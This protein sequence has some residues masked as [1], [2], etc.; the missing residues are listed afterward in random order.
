MTARPFRAALYIPGS[1]PRALDKARGLA[2]DA[3]LFD[4]EDAVS[5]DEKAAARKTLAEELEAGGYGERMR[6]VRMN[7]LGTDWGK[8]DATAIADMA[9]DAVLVPKVAGPD[10]VD[11]VRAL[12]PDLPV[13]AMIES[14]AG[15]L[16]AAAIAA[17]PAMQGFVIGTND[18]A[19]DLGSRGRPALTTALQMTLL[20]A[21][22]AGIS[23]SGR[24]RSVR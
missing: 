17:H 15:V 2:V 14:P 16:N 8:D 18:L 10:D 23:C 5:P 24:P 12:I 9:C 7:G 22:A 1:K 3:I 6:I 20:A 4:L 21:R 13:W 11:A 19:K